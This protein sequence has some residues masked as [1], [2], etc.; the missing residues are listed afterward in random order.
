MCYRRRRRRRRS[1]PSPPRQI[2]SLPPA[3]LPLSLFV[4]IRSFVYPTRKRKGRE[5]DGRSWKQNEKGKERKDVH[6][7]RLKL[8]LA[9]SI[10]PPPWSNNSSLQKY[11]P[12]SLARSCTR[13]VLAPFSSFVLLPYFARVENFSLFLPLATRS[14]AILSPSFSL[15]MQLRILKIDDRL[16]K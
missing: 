9:S 16:R 12:R 8:M 6:L 3:F 1:S 14:Y 7:D 10:S 15:S 5:S 11:F 13:H 4:R 2:R